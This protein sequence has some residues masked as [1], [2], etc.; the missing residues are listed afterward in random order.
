[1]ITTLQ[2]LVLVGAVLAAFSW[3][4]SALIR[5]PDTLEMALTGEKSPSGYMKRQSKWSAIAAV[6]AAVSAISQAVLA[7]VQI[8]N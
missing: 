7:Y 4:Y 3:L 5:I 8:S 1:M 6:F 2:V